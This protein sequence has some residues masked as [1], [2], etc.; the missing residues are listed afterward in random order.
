MKLLFLGHDYKYAVEQMLLALF[1]DERPE[2]VTASGEA[3]DDFALVSFQPGENAARAFCRMTFDGKS[4]EGEYS[5]PSGGYSDAL[6]KERAYQKAVRFAFFNAAEKIT[7]SIPP[8]GAL[9]GIRP[10]R[11]ASRRLGSGMSEGDTFRALT[12]EYFVSKDR[13]ELCMDAAKASMR[14]MSLI[15][16]RDISLYVGIPFCPTRC[17]YCSFVSSSVEKSFS[18]IE[19]YLGA[20]FAEIRSGA[21]LVRSLGLNISTVYIGGGTPT[22]LTAKQLDALLFELENNFDLSHL[23]EYT[24]EAGRPDTVDDEKIAVLKTHGVTRV[25][26]NPQTMDDAVLEAIGRRHTSGDVL[27][28]MDIVRRGGMEHINM[29][30]IAGLPTDSVSGFRKT[31]E[32]VVSMG[33]DNITVHTL[34]L[35]KG[36]RILLDGF[37][38][39]SAGDVTQMLSCAA[40]LLPE[41]GFSPYY[42]YRQKYMSGSFENVGWCRENCECLYNIYIMEE[43][44]SILSLGAGGSTKMVDVKS[45]YIERAFNLKY[46]AEYIA[47]PEKIAANQ[48]AFADFYNERMRSAKDV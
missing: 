19:P 22:T 48:K 26:V 28:A 38:I 47:R 42:I 7:G 45:G 1:P 11:I 25:S 24:V 21:E 13:A 17:A 32:R 37:A 14:A 29:D 18:L 2:Y 40:E 5:V 36:S 12:D 39:P 16:P 8:W 6:S 44:Q 9:T 34:S 23:L 4:A 43:L 27:R 33:A 10:A 46:P 3:S 20:L 30:V 31:M 41:N 35:K 15:S